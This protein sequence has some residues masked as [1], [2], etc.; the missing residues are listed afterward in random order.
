MSNSRGPPHWAI[1][2]RTVV[3]HLLKASQELWETVLRPVEG[4]EDS[5][6]ALQQA[7]KDQQAAESAAQK[8]AER[9]IS[10]EAAAS[11]PED[12]AQMQKLQA[13]VALRRAEKDAADGAVLGATSATAQAASGVVL[14]PLVCMFSMAYG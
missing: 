12:E 13:A 10:S 9:L 11:A 8:A 6:V 2:A 1:T 5:E 3:P 7:R 4:Y 14:S